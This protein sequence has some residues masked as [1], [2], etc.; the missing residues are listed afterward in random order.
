MAH[1][2]SRDYTILAIYTVI[3]LL[4]YFDFQLTAFI[5]DVVLMWGF[6]GVVL[7]SLNYKKYQKV[8]DEEIMK[9]QIFSTVY[10]VVVIIIFYLIGGRTGAG[11]FFNE[12][13]LIFILLLSFFEIFIRWRKWE[14]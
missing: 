11:L 12:G 3:L 13:M 14:V 1:L 8:D 9:W 10:I 7:Y 6:A 5:P 4:D 2:T